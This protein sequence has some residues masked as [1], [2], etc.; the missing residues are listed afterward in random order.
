MSQQPPPP[1]P[2]EKPNGY[3]GGSGS[4]NNNHTTSVRI[5]VPTVRNG[6]RREIDITSLTDE[7]LN[8]LHEEDPFLFYSIFRPTRNQDLGF[9]DVALA[10][11]DNRNGGGQGPVMVERLGRLSTE[12]D[13]VTYMAR[14]LGMVADQGAGTGHQ[15]AGIPGNQ[16]SD[17]D[18]SG[19][20]SEADDD[21]EEMAEAAAQ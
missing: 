18:T 16:D 11:Q 19:T 13:A 17:E 12:V 4:D 15:G 2:N 6:E 8:L 7:Q 21:G 5:M 1:P 20:D 3:S 9:A 10:L 14:M